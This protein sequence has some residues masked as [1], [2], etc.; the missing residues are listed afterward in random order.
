MK[1]KREGIVRNGW[2]LLMGLLLL[3]TGPA[4]RGDSSQNGERKITKLVE[5]IYEIRH[6]DPIPSFVDGNTTVIIGERG[7]F[8]VD[9]GSLGSTAREDIAQIK[10]W[11]D[12]P[13]R[14]VLNTHWH[15]DHNN[16]NK[17]YMDAYP[18]VDI[19][20]Q[21]ETKR[22]MDGYYP[23]I[24]KAIMLP[25]NPTGQMFAD[26]KHMAETGTDKEGKPIADDRKA[27]VAA[28]VARLTEIAAEYDAFVYQPPTITF[29]KEMD[30]NLGNREVRVLF[31][32][33]GNTAGDA[34]IYLPKE[35][36]M[37]T[38]D[39]VV[40]PVPYTFDGYPTEWVETLRKMSEL[41]ATMIVPGHG[42]ILADKTYFHDLIELYQ[43][44]IQ[45]VQAQVFA[46]S[47]VTLENVQ[48]AVKLD[49]FRD[50]FVGTSPDAGFF[51]YAMSKFV[52]LAYNEMKAR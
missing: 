18:N 40:H 42:E 14:Y 36:I 23:G 16:G 13:V 22:L 24:V 41:D 12:K 48:K 29:E 5:G 33:R 39:L 21:A 32:G 26:L 19:I 30:I 8:V 43:S 52:E 25:Q 49:A 6:K 27:R 9:S 50:K 46:D 4:A 20:A 34:F 10:Q 51:D 15:A 44:V 31:F 28:R 38:G 47:D 1:F 2:F 37:A 7:V 35:K 45:Q 3:V 11:T 17:A